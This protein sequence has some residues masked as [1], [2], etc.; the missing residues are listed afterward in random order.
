MNFGSGTLHNFP[1]EV[2]VHSTF[3]QGQIEQLKVGI[4]SGLPGEGMPKKILV[5]I[6]K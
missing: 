4:V 1:F 6:V 3:S 2:P 5:A